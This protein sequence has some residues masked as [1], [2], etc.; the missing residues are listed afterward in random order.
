M[1]SIKIKLRSTKHTMVEAKTVTFEE[2]RAKM[3][4]VSAEG[5]DAE[6]MAVAEEMRKFKADIQK[7][8][9]DK[10]KA[11]A[12]ALAGKREAEETRLFP[13]ILSQ[14]DAKALLELKAKGFTFVI[15]HKEDDK[16][17]LDPDGTV[18]VT[19]SLK[20]MVPTVKTRTG[21][22]GGGG[23]GITVESQT[24]LKREQLI[25]TYATDEE[26]ATIQK[27]KDDATARGGN[28]NSSG[29]SAS[30]PIVKRILADHPELIKK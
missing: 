30:K 7:A 26:K 8:E 29:W 14:V 11:E 17:R 13:I 4:K 24:G 23:T 16:G 2:L 6:I 28:P 20:L 3:A 21:G 15:D 25:E 22:G 12:D 9:A 19:G 10:A 18:K 1:A 5:T 27:A